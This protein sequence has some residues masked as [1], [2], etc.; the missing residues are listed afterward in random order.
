MVSAVD[1]EVTPFEMVLA[2]TGGV[3]PPVQG[4][5]A[6]GPAAPTL[7]CQQLDQ[8]AA[9]AAG[10]VKPSQHFP[11]AMAG[12]E[13]LEALALV[14]AVVRLLAEVAVLLVE[15][16]APPMVHL[17]AVVAVV[18]HPVAHLKEAVVVVVLPSGRPEVAV[19]AA[20]HL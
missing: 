15:V 14:V 4:V 12:E 6:A 20:D 18:G 7:E 16:A 11:Q 9:A 1:G 10:A 3:L 13:P 5:A 2:Q 8:K 19:V 17:E